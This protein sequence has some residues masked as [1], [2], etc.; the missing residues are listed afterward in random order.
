LS[1]GHAVDI[2]TS[3]WCGVKAGQLGGGRVKLRGTID[4]VTL[5]TLA[6]RDDIASLTAGYGLIV[7]VGAIECG[8]HPGILDITHGQCSITPNMARRIPAGYAPCR[9]ES[10]PGLVVR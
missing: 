4:V 7:A 9:A 5:Q 10:M 1:C 8:N 2:G 6:R 3:S